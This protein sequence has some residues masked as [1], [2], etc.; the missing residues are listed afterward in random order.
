MSFNHQTSFIWLVVPRWSSSCGP[1]YHP[2]TSYQSIH[3]TTASLSPKNR[4]HASFVVPLLK[5][6]HDNL[7]HT[8]AVKIL[9]GPLH[10]SCFRQVASG[11]GSTVF[12]TFSFFSSSDVGAFLSSR[13]FNNPSGPF[14]CTKGYTAPFMTVIEVILSVI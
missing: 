13:G 3:G 8:A 14:N 1:V 7:S 5:Y 11:T 9:V 12:F 10:G 2:S 6:L 4:S